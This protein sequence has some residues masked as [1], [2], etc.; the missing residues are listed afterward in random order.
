MGEIKFR[1]WIAWGNT[2]KMIFTEEKVFKRAVGF[3]AQ[4]DMVQMMEMSDFK[5]LNWMQF[6][7]LLDRR[8]KEIYKGDVI[9][10]NLFDAKLPTM[11]VVEYD[12]EHACFANKNQAGLT[13]ILK[14]DRIE[15]IG[16]IWEN[17]E[18]M[19]TNP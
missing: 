6:T 8:G 4:D 13:P 17:P 3:L 14:I 5:G 18:L 16:N 19:E 7:G 2:G 12:T 15:V 1:A 10:G 9:E 11:G